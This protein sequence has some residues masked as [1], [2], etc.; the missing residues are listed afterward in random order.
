[1]VTHHSPVERFGDVGCLPGGSAGR[2]AAANVVGPTLLGIAIV[3]S[4]HVSARI[5]SAA[6]AWCFECLSAHPKVPPSGWGTVEW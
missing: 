4:Q 2:D 6:S 1:M 3:I 5:R